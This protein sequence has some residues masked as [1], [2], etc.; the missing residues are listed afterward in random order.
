MGNLVGP[1]VVP[2]VDP[3]VGRGSLSPALCVA[4]NHNDFPSQGSDRKSVS[5]GLWCV[6]GFGAEFCFRP[7][8]LRTA[9]RSKTL[10]KG[11]L[12]FCAKSW[13]KRDL[14]IPQNFRSEFAESYRHSQQWTFAPLIRH[15]SLFYFK[16]RVR[17]RSDFRPAIEI[18]N[19]N[20]ENPTIFFG[21]LP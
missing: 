4:H 13:F 1:R 6:P 2:L 8:T 9:E 5:T 21:A 12:V 16:E 14:N 11:T 7:R 17:N 10:K 15:V 20:R 18:R 3:L 19:R